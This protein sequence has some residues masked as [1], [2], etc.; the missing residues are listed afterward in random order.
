MKLRSVILIGGGGHCKS[1]IDLILATQLYTIAGIADVK[2]NMGKT[3]LGFPVIGTDDDLDSLKKKCDV[4]AVTVGQ[5]KSPATRIKIYNRLSEVGAE[6]PSIFSP[7]AYISTF[8]KI[9][10]GT[11]VFHRAVVN[12][13]VVVGN[14]CIVNNQALIDHDVMIEDHCHISTAAVLNGSVQ[15]KEGGFIGSNATLQ[16]GVVIGAYSIV[17]AASLVL[18][19]VGD[20][21]VVGGVPAKVI[22]QNE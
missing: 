16:Q 4:F 20:R 19:N 6:M 17:G 14:N 11:L 7:S 10:S 13:G 9:G 15:V 1:C 3:V 18:K 2:E 21:E 12:A 8:A 22:R 5:I